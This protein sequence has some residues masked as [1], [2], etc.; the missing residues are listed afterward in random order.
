MYNE[1]NSLTSMHKI[2]LEG[3]HVIKI[4]QPIFLLFSLSLFLFSPFS[5]PILHTLIFSLLR[6]LFLFQ[7]LENLV[8]SKIL[9]F[10]L[11]AVFKKRMKCN[12]KAIE[13]KDS[14]F[15]YPVCMILFSPTTKYLFIKFLESI[16][17]FNQ[18]S[19]FDY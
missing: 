4:N 19:T 2:T 17:K 16:Q 1:C 11:N 9:R 18:E 8:F 5:L 13:K 12:N 10:L 14:L 15:S 7:K 6:S 3:L